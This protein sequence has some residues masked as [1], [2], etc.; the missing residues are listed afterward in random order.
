MDRPPQ[1]N[2]NAPKQPSKAPPKGLTVEI[3][4]IGLAVALVAISVVGWSAYRGGGAYL[5]GSQSVAQSQ[6]I[7]RNVD[8]VRSEG[9]A[10]VEAA[11]GYILSGN[12]RM[13]DEFRGAIGRIRQDVTHLRVL[14]ADRKSQLARVKAIE[15]SIER[16]DRVGGVLQR[17][18]ATQNREAVMHS[19]EFGQLRQEVE[20]VREHL[21][22]IDHEEQNTLLHRSALAQDAARYSTVLMAVGGGIV[23]IWLIFTGGFASFLVTR[24]RRTTTALEVSRQELQQANTHLEERVRDRSAELAHQNAL[25]GSILNSMPDAI[26]M[27]EKDLKPVLMNPAAERGLRLGVE[28]PADWLRD[29]DLFLPGSTTPLRPGDQPFMVRAL[30]GETIEGFSCARSNARPETNSGSISPCAPCRPRMGLC[31]AVCWWFVM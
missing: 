29:Y 17:M 6:S 25:L 12:P 10:A 30:A 31:A 4:W 9:H 23:I 1:S 26:V 13:L 27:V 14:L 22:E 2:S 11:D 19:E 18:A 20:T 5:A 7:I 8:Q 28:Q 16:L 3:L 24:Y 15:D 21:V